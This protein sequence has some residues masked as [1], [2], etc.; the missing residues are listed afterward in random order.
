MSDSPER[1][2][3]RVLSSREIYKGRV[4]HLVVEEVV[5]PN[6]NQAALEVI[7]HPGAAA[8]VPFVSA[9]EVLLVRQYRHATAGAPGGGY[10]LEVPAGKLDPGEAPEACA[11]RETEEEIGYQVG[12]LVR[13]G[14]IFTTPGFT[15]EV[16]H[17]FAGFDLVPTAAKLGPDEV[18][19][20]ERVAFADAVTMVERGEIADSKS[21]AAILL[22]ARKHS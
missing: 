1:T 3:A 9:S 14:V 4:V 6:G 7:H 8:V 16:I 22:A 21:V 15:D 19:S 10:L 11:W 2:P 5:L 12:R 13:L 17:L 20:V 18:L